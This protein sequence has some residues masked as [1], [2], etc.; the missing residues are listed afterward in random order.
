MPCSL[1]LKTLEAAATWYVQLNDGTVSEA[2][3]RAW[4]AWLQSSPQHAAAWA[5]VET[6]QQQWSMMPKQAAL[7]SLGAAKAQRR[8]VLK[9]LSML[10]AV[11]G[12]SWLAVEQVPYRA[13]LAEQ[14]TGRR[15]RRS[16]RLDDGSQLDMNADTALDIRFD[17]EQ[18]HIQLYQGEMLVQT[19][20]A[21]DPRP[22]VVHTI[23]GSVRALG[24]RFSVRQLPEQTRVCVLQA[25]VEVRP[26]QHVE[27][28][29]R[30]EVGQQ[31][32][33]DRDEVDE[34]QRLP[35]GSTAW[36]QG[37][38]SV[39]DWRLGDFVEALGRYRPGVLRCD[40]AVQGLSISGAF[41]IDDTDT[42]LQ[43]LSKTLPVK[44]RYM[45]R[46]W[47]SIEPA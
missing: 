1:D 9:I 23:D 33:F 12:A 34:I 15:E 32:T 24:T 20:K 16:L 46:Y 41:R 5:R 29:V 4:Q 19:A 39:D 14:R 27:R 43:N 7:S 35:A 22:F 18:R 42:V 3:H 6:L 38:L 13:M 10:V 11:G 44:V 30:L 31:V 45:T 17:S 47:A 37:M 28:P 2:R 26:L 21:W 8:D 40:P 36:V 25:A